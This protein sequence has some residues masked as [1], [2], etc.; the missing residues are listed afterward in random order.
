MY[1]AVAMLRAERKFVAARICP[2]GNETLDPI[3]AS[4]EVRGGYGSKRKHQ[5]RAMRTILIKSPICLLPPPMRG[6]MRRVGSLRHIR[7]DLVSPVDRQFS[8]STG[9]ILGRR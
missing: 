8:R 9:L 6:Y 5:V 3:S 4:K 2:W 1:L 7:I